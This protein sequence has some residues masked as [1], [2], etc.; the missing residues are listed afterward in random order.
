MSTISAVVLEVSWNPGGLSVRLAAMTYCL[1][2]PFCCSIGRGSHDRDT[3][4]DVMLVAIKLPGTAVGTVVEERDHKHNS[5]S[6]LVLEL[7]VS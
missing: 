3:V 1:I 6:N 2:I 7:L 5:V 4:R